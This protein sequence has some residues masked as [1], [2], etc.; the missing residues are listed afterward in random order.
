MIGN[1]PASQNRSYVG[2]KVKSTTGLD[3]G[4]ISEILINHKTGK[5]E[6]GIFSFGGFLGMGKKQIAAPIDAL[7]FN[8]NEHYFELDVDSDILEDTSSLIEFQGKNYFIF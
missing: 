5:I 3:L 7:I 8:E 4:E 2:E 6:Y 1:V